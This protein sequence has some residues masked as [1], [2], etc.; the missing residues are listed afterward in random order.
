MKK[1]LLAI[2]LALSMALTL[3]PGAA[4]AAEGEEPEIGFLD[5]SGE[6]YDYLDNALLFDVYVAQLVFGEEAG[7]STYDFGKDVLTDSAEIALYNQLQAQI[8]AV[9]SGSSTTT[10]TRFKVDSDATPAMGQLSKIMKCLITDHPEQLYWWGRSMITRISQSEAQIM[11]SV[12]KMFVAE[13]P[14]TE[15]VDGKTISLTVDSSKIINAKTAIGNAAAIISRHAS[16]DDYTKLKSYKEEICEAVS[17]NFAALDSMGTAN[18]YEFGEHAWQIIYVFDG[19]S[20]TKVVCE[21]Y[22]KA[23]QY[24]CNNSTFRSNNIACYT[25]TGTMGGA[26]GA[27]DHMWNVVTMEDGKNYL[28]DV[29]NCDLSQRG[30]TTLE[31]KLPKGLTSLFLAGASGSVTGTY[32]VKQPEYDFSDG[33]CIEARDTTF[34]YDA[35]TRATYGDAV[36]TLESAN[37]TYTPPVEKK[38]PVCTAPAGLTA[39]YGQTLADVTLTG[40]TAEVDNTTV[41]GT[42]SWKT[43]GASVGNVGSHTFK[44]TFDP[45]DTAAYN[46]VTGIDVSVTVNAKNI[47]VTVAAIPDQPYTGSAI[48]PDVTVTSTETVGGYTL[49]KDT[50][51]TVTYEGNTGVGQA[52]VKI[53]SKSGSNYTFTEVTKTFQIT[54]KPASITIN[55]PGTITYDGD[56]VTAGTSGADLIYTY[57]GDSSTINV[58]WYDSNGTLRTGEPKDAG[59]YQI[60]VSAEAGTTSAAV[61]EVKE[62]FTISPADYTYAGPGTRSVSV[63]MNHPAASSVSA[64]G[65]RGESVS[66]QLTWYTDA[67]YTVPAN[68][69]FSTAGKTTLYWKFTP[70]NSATN[71]VSTPKTG[72]VEFTVDSLPQQTLTFDLT[73]DQSRSFGDAAFTNAANRTETDGG[74]VTYASSNTAVAT[75]DSAGEVTITG[76]GTTVITA[77][78][79]RVAGKYAETSISYTLTVTAK[80]INPTVTVTGGPFTYTGSEIK[81]GVSVKAGS[82]DIPETGYSVAYSNNINAGT[83]TVTVTAAAGGNYT[84]TAKSQTFTIGKA[85]AP[86]AQTQTVPVAATATSG[87]AVLVS[88]TVAGIFGTKT[89]TVDVVT[90]D[91]GILSGTPAVDAG[92]KLTFSLADNLAEK[93][94]KTAAISVTVSSTN[95]ENYTVTVTVEVV[96]K[97]TQAAPAAPVLTYALNADRAT[98]TVTIP[99]VAGAEYSFD[100][101]NWSDTNVKTDVAPNTDVTG[102][103]RM[104]ETETQL[105]SESASG[106][107]TTPGIPTMIPQATPAAGS[108]SGD[109]TVTLTCGDAD[110]VI[111]YTTDGSVPSLTAAGTT[112]RY[113]GPFTVTPPATVNAFAYASGKTQSE[114]LT[115]V[116]AKQAIE[117]PVIPP[118]IPDMPSGGGSSS[119]GSSSGG[120]QTPSEPSA[121]SEPSV[122]PGPSGQEVTAA[123]KADVS[124]ST[125]S[126]AVS[127]ATGR[128]LVDQAVQNGS[129]TV[130]IAP[131]VTGSVSRTE[132]SI[133]SGVVGD[134][135]GKTSAALKV[136]TPAA[137]VTIPNEAL[138]A[139]AAR[140]GEV[141]VAAGRDNSIISLEITASGRTVETVSGG[142][143]VTV[144]EPGCT[145]GTV[146]MLMKEDG[147]SEI[148]RQS[149]A[150]ASAGTV[151]V[152]LDGSARIVL[153]D[154]SKRFSDVSASSWASDAVAFVSSRELMNGAGE[155]AFTPNAPMTRGMLAVVLHN[156]EGNPDGSVSAAFSDVTGGWYAEAVSWAAGRNII[157]GYAGGEFRP[158]GEITREQLAVM[159][160]RYAGSPAVSGSSLP[161]SDAASVSGYARE[162]IAWAS[163]NGIMSGKGGGVLDPQGG[164]TRA[165]VAQMLLNFVASLSK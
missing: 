33:T 135:A 3:L 67:G 99:A 5:F 102:Y 121:P 34:A 125:A 53:T 137:S 165:E 22:A 86:E 156:L 45:M 37:Y 77:T 12:D 43:P 88:P 105:A 30:S 49:K 8:E 128:E 157:T 161:F 81:P 4:L 60:G 17:Y 111:Y 73:G 29:T 97:Q 31:E 57:T 10:S 59:T 1:R 90:N 69:T 19:D 65:V 145:A 96:A 100:G 47:A 127:N 129:E 117:P 55:T 139:L 44:A 138:P 132:V 14:D 144:R 147:S 26:N 76:V 104:K 140:G 126:A 25:V 114:L 70:D 79:A 155:G 40:G 6:E 154:N 2:L 42:W 130:V 38:T 52:T 85:A 68:G 9:A 32:T 66:G 152:P 21:G 162:A 39:T 71:Y 46:T 123:P 118:Y 143:T 141:T 150:D 122:T 120:N 56:P 98:Y 160:Y 13:N 91:D 103:I 163:A 23:F 93:V 20:G 87:E 83:A 75:V 151:T 164:A 36:L 149:V 28:V 115:V 89:Y 148:I 82:T 27:G 63:G 94:G 136:E 106:S 16:E 124:G 54:P 24:L 110:A 84:W 119:G 72:S 95:Y 78:A 131:V 11:L 48:T 80:S 18:G 74:A 146:A 134:I 153:V 7:F 51:Y 108:Y 113:T 109:V 116:Y 159:L 133:P 62:T 112:Q 92:G 61:S 41:E 158:D 35:E 58:K 50:D 64:S 142:V 101:T 15:T 107:V